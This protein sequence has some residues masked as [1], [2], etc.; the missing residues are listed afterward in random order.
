[1][2]KELIYI[3]QEPQAQ[4]LKSFCKCC[5]QQIRSQSKQRTRRVSTHHPKQKSDRFVDISLGMELNNLDNI[6][7]VISNSMNSI[8]ASYN[9]IKQGLADVEDP[10]YTGLL[11]SS[12]YFMFTTEHLGSLENVLCKMEY[13][14][15]QCKA[16][17][18]GQVGCLIIRDNEYV[19]FWQVGEV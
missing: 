8:K 9:Y 2:A 1:M 3:E 16:I 11:E 19:F 15:F 13:C 18:F 10:R 14:N 4:N 6:E 5:G 7:W 17:R 12:G